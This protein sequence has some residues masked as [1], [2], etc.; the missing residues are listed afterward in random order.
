MD[1][2]Q[3]TKFIKLPPSIIYITFIITSILLLSENTFLEKLALQEFKTE[4]NLYIGIVF[5]LSLRK[6]GEIKIYRKR[7]LS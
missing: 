3:F 6:R 1:M 5:L 4:Y 2:S 7:F